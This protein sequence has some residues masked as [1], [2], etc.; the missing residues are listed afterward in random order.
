MRGQQAR[1]LLRRGGTLEELPEVIANPHIQKLRSD[2]LQGEAKLQELA[3]QYGANYP[4]YQRLQS[5]NRALR[6][7]IDAEMR[8][9]LAGLEASA[10]Q[11]GQR[12]AELKRALAA[13]RSRLLELLSRPRSGRA[14]PDVDWIRQCMDSHGSIAYAQR[15]AHALAGA[16][17][18]EFDTVLA[19]VPPSS[20]REF[21]RAVIR[22][23][24]TRT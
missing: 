4:Q 22:W 11:S 20:D 2:L 7:K 19:D 23:V 13:Q 15:I 6:E 24:L 8:K 5:E 3:T 12:E 10:R 14:E 21:L 1:E 16:A 18:H 17:Q 9:I